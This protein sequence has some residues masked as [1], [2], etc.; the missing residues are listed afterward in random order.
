MS[1]KTL[2]LLY[3]F[4]GFLRSGSTS[5]ELPSSIGLEDGEEEPIIDVCR[6]TFE[7][8]IGEG[9]K[10]LELELMKN[11]MNLKSNSNMG[12]MISILCCKQ[13]MQKIETPRF[14][15]NPKYYNATRRLDSRALEKNKA[16][17]KQYEYAKLKFN[18]LCLSNEK[19]EE[20]LHYI[21]LKAFIVAK[22]VRHLHN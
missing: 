18:T 8:G 20:A 7:I 21:N 11:N 15:K 22:F 17:K 5:L 10:M 2:D 12:A 14:K 6:D 9:I 19:L 4:L 1:W 16:N 13:K 3:D